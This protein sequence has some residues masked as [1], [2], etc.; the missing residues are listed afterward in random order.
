MVLAA[1]ADLHG[2]SSGETSSD[3]LDAD[4]DSSLTNTTGGESRP[5]EASEPS[6]G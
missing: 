1:T 6:R 3:D 2:R 4:Q 5:G